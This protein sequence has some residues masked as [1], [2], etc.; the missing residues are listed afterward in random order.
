MV[1]SSLLYSAIPTSITTISTILVIQCTTYQEYR[2]NLYFHV[3]LLISL[4]LFQ[5]VLIVK[6]H[7][8]ELESHQGYNRTTDSNSSNVNY[9]DKPQMEFANFITEMCYLQVLLAIFVSLIHRNQ[10]LLVRRSHLSSSLGP[11]SSLLWNI[12]IAIIKAGAKS[13]LPTYLL[14]IY[15]LLYRN[16]VRKDHEK[17]E[18][19]IASDFVNHWQV[20]LLPW[21]I[22]L[23]GLFTLWAIKRRREIIKKPVI[24]KYSDSLPYQ[25]GSLSQNDNEHHAIE[26]GWRKWTTAQLL[27]WVRDVYYEQMLHQNQNSSRADYFQ[28]ATSNNIKYHRNENDLQTRNQI[29]ID[30]DD[31]TLIHIMETIKKQRLNG[32]VLPYVTVEDLVTMGIAYSHSVFLYTRFRKLIDA[33]AANDLNGR[34]TDREQ[35]IDLDEWLGKKISGVHHKSSSVSNKPNDDCFDG[36]GTEYEDDVQTTNSSSQQY[37]HV[38]DIMMDKFG[39][40]LPQLKNPNATTHQSTITKPSSGNSNY[41]T[42]QTNLKSSSPTAVDFNYGPFESTPKLDQKLLDAMPPNIRD[43]ASRRPDL[44]MAMQEKF[45]STKSQAVQPM[46]IIKRDRTVRFKDE[47]LDDGKL[48]STEASLNVEYDDEEGSDEFQSHKL[49]YN[50]TIEEAD[51][52]LGLLRRR[53]VKS[54]R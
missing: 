2:D 37:D 42:N 36:E 26:S 5:N 11:K 31:D 33:I 44:V 30:I 47:E 4:M 14:C 41:S 15:M 32:S 24:R 49:G 40:E 10:P 20:E 9:E 38:K 51:E 50:E 12:F 39:L 16:L 28:H 8:L 52:M 35:S 29:R 13:L 46:N 23:W 25:F 7:Y 1:H 21:F 45:K 6:T 19:E 27:S 43:I 53:R 34:S 22:I 48:A 54:D 17:D 3:A 18:N